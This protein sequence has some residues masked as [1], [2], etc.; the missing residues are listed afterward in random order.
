MDFFILF[1]NQ[2]IKKKI[3][4]VI[5]FILNSAVRTKFVDILNGVMIHYAHFIRSNGAIAQLV[6]RLN[7]IQEVRSSKLL[8]STKFCFYFKWGISS[9]G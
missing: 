9:V 7:G 5:F 1:V 2:Y 8:S 3:V 6:E 4:S